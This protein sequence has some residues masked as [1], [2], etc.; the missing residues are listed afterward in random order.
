ML[1]KGRTREQASAQFAGEWEEGGVGNAFSTANRRFAPLKMP[2]LP[3]SGGPTQSGGLKGRGQCEA[4]HSPETPGTLS[5]WPVR[6][7]MSPKMIE[8][9]RAAALS[10]SLRDFF[11]KLRRPAA[12][13][14]TTG[15]FFRFISAFPQA[16]AWLRLLPRS[17][18]AALFFRPQSPCG[19]LRFLRKNRRPR[20]DSAGT[21]CA[22]PRPRPLF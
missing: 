15:R 4:L 14:E 12:S 7:R 20:R 6:R 10:N 16:A 21:G 8:N 13:S 9:E 3:Y 1:R 2:F 18:A 22:W 17:F 5:A 11:E 19:T